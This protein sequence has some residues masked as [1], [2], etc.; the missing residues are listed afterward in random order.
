MLQDQ[1]LN[2]QGAL[3]EVV[4]WNGELSRDS[5]A[6]LKYSAWRSQLLDNLQEE[7][8][9]NLSNKID[10]FYAIVLEREPRLLQLDEKDRRSWPRPL[11]RR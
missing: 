5:S 1:H 6:A 8:L 10:D 11:S 2:L 4:D 7:G 9:R 3:Q